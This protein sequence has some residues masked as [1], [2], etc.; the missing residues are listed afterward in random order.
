MI[1]DDIE[2]SFV[3]QYREVTIS[4]ASDAADSD[5]GP[6][7]LKALSQTFPFPRLRGKARMGA[8]GQERP[9]APSLTLPRKRGRE[10]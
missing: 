4:D 9:T 2:R 8:E 1:F 7:S 10:E 3:Y 5:D 6:S